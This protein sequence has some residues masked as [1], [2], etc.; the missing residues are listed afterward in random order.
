MTECI[1]DKLELLIVVGKISFLLE[2]LPS[3]G[4][5]GHLPHSLRRGGGLG[6]VP[7]LSV[8]CLAPAAVSRCLLLPALLSVAV[9]PAVRTVT[10]TAVPHHAPGGQENVD[11]VMK[12]NLKVSIYQ[13]QQIYTEGRVIC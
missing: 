4:L 7:G 8:S 5:A 9:K 12:T 13:K 6:L 11:K 1:D 2:G 10:L 3:D